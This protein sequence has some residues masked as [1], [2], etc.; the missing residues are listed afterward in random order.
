MHFPTHKN[1]I[2]RHAKLG[3]SKSLEVE[4]VGIPNL[5]LKFGGTFCAILVVDLF[6]L[7]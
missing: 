2:I 3:F 6:R 4:V 1:L 7:T 5:F